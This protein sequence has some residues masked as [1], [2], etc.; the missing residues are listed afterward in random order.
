LK[1]SVLSEAYAA[2]LLIGGG[3]REK[4]TSVNEQQRQT[5]NEL[6]KLRLKRKDAF[7]CDKSTNKKLK[8]I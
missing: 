6:A 1:N 8:S 7:L 5:T 2:K 3:R 4:L